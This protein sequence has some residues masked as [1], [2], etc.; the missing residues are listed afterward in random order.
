MPGSLSAAE[1]QQLQALQ[2]ELVA[3][4]AKYG[5]SLRLQKAATV[6]SADAPFPIDIFL[7]LPAPTAAANY[8]V[9]SLQVL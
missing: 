7:A 3:L 6:D 2:A 1:V 9:E 4:K 5:K 8:D